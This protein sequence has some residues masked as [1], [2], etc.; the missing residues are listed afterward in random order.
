MAATT[1]TSKAARK[2]HTINA[3]RITFSVD[4]LDESASPFT[5]DGVDE[6]SGSF[7]GPSSGCRSPAS[8]LY[9]PSVALFSRS[10]FADVVITV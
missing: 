6:S 2:A 1:V 9:T 4:C 3:G 7:G 10:I 5:D 8:E